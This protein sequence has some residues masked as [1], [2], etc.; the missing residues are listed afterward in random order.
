VIPKKMAIIAAMAL[1]IIPVNTSV[2]F[3][4]KFV[5]CHLN[6]PDVPLKAYADRNE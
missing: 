1:R 5:T 3:E 2:L 6:A 4:A